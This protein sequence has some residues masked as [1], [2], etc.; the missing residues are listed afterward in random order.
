MVMKHE[1]ISVDAIDPNPHRNLERNPINPE[2]VEKLVDSIGRTG[3]W[4]NVV[5]RKHPEIKGR[6]QLAYGHNR[7]EALRLSDISEVRLPIAELSKW[8]MY[9]A[10]VD[11]NDTQQTITPQIA[12]ENIESGLELIEEAL[13]AI[14]KKGTEE[15]FCQQLGLVVSTDTTKTWGGHGFVQVRNDYFNEKGIGRRF[16]EDFLPSCKLRSNAISDLLKAHYAE[17]REQEAEAAE[18][19]AD[20]AEELAESEE[21]AAK[22]LA[23][24]AEAEELRRLADEKRREAEKIGGK[25]IATKILMS[26]ENTRQM[27]DFA[28][29]VRDLEISKS[30]HAKAAKLIIDK[31]AFGKKMR[32]ELTIWWYEAS[33]QAGRDRK[34]ESKK[35]AWDA[36]R[37]KVKDGDYQT[38]LMAMRSNVRETTSEIKIAT[39]D[40]VGRYAPLHEK[41]REAACKDLR[42]LIQAAETLIRDLENQEVDDQDDIIINQSRLSIGSNGKQLHSF[43]ESN[44]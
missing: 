8:D 39:T 40:N 2:Q 23:L 14:G 35:K 6:F 1:M 18:Q 17:R 41:I 22:R 20:E 44:S 19:A 33:G 10:M 12:L 34:R 27:T 11:E 9:C 29:C 7:L 30:H 32:E 24:E 4:E 13:D 16:I 38:Y 36:F 21:D 28:T 31:G 26:F 43:E 3:F 5:V 15:E 42:A 25:A 37:K